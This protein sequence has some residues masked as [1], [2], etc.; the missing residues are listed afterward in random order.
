VI[1][2][3]TVTGLP[4]EI[5]LLGERW[6]RKREFHMTAVLARVVA[7]GLDVVARVTDGRS[8]GPVAIGREIRRVRDPSGDELRTLVVMAE[9]PGLDPLYGELSAALG[10][11]LV[12]P[13]A[14]VTIYSSDPDRGIGLADGSELRERT[15]VLG[16]ADQA[17]L[18]SLLERAAFAAVRPPP[19][20]HAP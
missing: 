2:P 17:E 7:F 8:V 1:A 4:P 3:L 9:C 15:M 20:P 10:V 5:E 16:E 12:A 6:L 11:R 13:P 19:D 18:R 14:H